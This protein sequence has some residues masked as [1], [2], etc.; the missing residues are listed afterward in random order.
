MHSHRVG[1][2]VDGVEAD[3]KL[4]DEVDIS[5]LGEGLDERR[6]AG[7]RHRAELVDQVVLGHAAA[8]VD[9]REGL[10]V[11]VGNELHLKL[12]SLRERTAKHTNRHAA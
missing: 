10:L 8:T 9:E 12:G 5:A 4:A 6:G 1:D 11:L 2:E 3:T 7:L